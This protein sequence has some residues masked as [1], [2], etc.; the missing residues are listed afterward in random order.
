MYVYFKTQP[1][2]KRKSLTI[3][4][5]RFLC[6]AARTVVPAQPGAPSC[7]GHHVPSLGRTSGVVMKLH[8]DD[9]QK[10]QIASRREFEDSQ[11]CRFWFAPS[12]VS[13]HG[14]LHHSAKRNVLVAGRREDPLTQSVRTKGAGTHPHLFVTVL[15]RVLAALALPPQLLQLGL[16]LLQALPFALVLHL[17]LL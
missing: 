4:L 10:E 8:Q 1:F 3:S 15:G 17:V 11:S 14:D 5:K 2:E 12:K 7:S 9:G 6:Q 16:A 13:S